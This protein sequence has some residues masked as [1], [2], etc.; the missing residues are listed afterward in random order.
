MEYNLCTN[1]IL[2]NDLINQFHHIVFH[3]VW[4]VV[5]I[6]PILIIVRFSV[7]VTENHKLNIICNF[8]AVAGT[9]LLKNWQEQSRFIIYSGRSVGEKVKV[10]AGLNFW[11]YLRAEYSIDPIATTKQKCKSWRDER[12]VTWKLWA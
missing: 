2:Q 12:R 4:N 9:A 6:N 3:I 5:P 11:M 8:G 1:L 10:R 7:L